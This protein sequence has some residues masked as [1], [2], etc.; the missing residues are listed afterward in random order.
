[1]NSY[2]VKWAFWS[3]FCSHLTSYLTFSVFAS[4]I[5][6]EYLFSAQLMVFPF[7]PFFFK[8]VCNMPERFLTRARTCCRYVGGQLSSLWKMDWNLN[9]VVL[10]FDQLPGFFSQSHLP[11]SIPLGCGHDWW[12]G[13]TLDGP[14][15][16]ER[17]QSS[18]IA[19]HRADLWWL[20]GRLL[21]SYSLSKQSSFWRKRGNSI[22]SHQ[23]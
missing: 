13:W 9:L 2:S 22:I 12:Q 10:W 5:M 14:K 4:S 7:F 3:S 17:L 6:S 16:W 23:L 20:S 15:M 1:M 18:W 19:P 21:V 8:G 11:A